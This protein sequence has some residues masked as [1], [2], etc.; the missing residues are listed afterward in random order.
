MTVKGT[1]GMEDTELQETAAEREQLVRLCAHLSGNA[2]ASEDLAQETLIEAWRH[3]QSLRDPE[4]RSAWLAGIARNVCK[5]WLRA[6]GQVTLQ[7]MESAGPADALDSITDETD[8][9]VELERAELAILL[10][11]AMALLPPETRDVLVERFIN[12]LSH[13]EIA[14]RL[15]VSEGTVKVRV[16]RGKLALRRVLTTQFAHDLDAYGFAAQRDGWRETRVW[17]PGCGTRTLL[18]HVGGPDDAISFRC[19]GCEPEPQMIA[20]RYPLANPHFSQLVGDLKHPMAVLRRGSQWLYPYFAR[21]EVGGEVPC[22]RCGMPVTVRTYVREGIWQGG[23]RGGLYVSCEACGEELCTSR[24]GL[25]LSVPDVLTFRREQA[26]VR[27]LPAGEVETEGRPA[28]VTRVQSVTSDVAL[29]VVSDA[30]T[31]RIL[32]IHRESVP[33]AAI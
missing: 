9:E 2:E 1:F 13:A 4:K 8:I 33:G 31:Y 26:R 6:R 11:R 10:D 19:P 5:R 28:A 17:C 3:Q 14:E 24:S 30:D 16:H 27:I 18:M 25:V 12:D 32:G 21:T 23:Q 29:A 22:T 7:T 15:S 20:T